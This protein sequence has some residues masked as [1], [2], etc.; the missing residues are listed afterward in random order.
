M[1]NWGHTCPCLIMQIPRKPSARC[2][3]T[4]PPQLCF[5]QDCNSWVCSFLNLFLAFLCYLGV[6]SGHCYL[7]YFHASLSFLPPALKKTKEKQ[8][9]GGHPPVYKIFWFHSLT[10]SAP[11]NP[12]FLLNASLQHECWLGCMSSQLILLSCNATGLWNPVKGFIF[13]GW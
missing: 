8:L 5:R 2:L 13:L 10:L 6:A 7:L 3:T 12:D 1:Q 9:E 4:G 11:Q